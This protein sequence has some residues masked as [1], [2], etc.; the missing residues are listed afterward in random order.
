MAGDQKG[1]SDGKDP[2]AATKEQHQRYG[3]CP[4]TSI[5]PETT[6]NGK[7]G[8]RKETELLENV[9]LFPWQAH[10]GKARWQARACY[11]VTMRPA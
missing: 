5:S 9:K 10:A 4:Q 7:A 2:A 6:K 3:A 1:K 11:P 8:H